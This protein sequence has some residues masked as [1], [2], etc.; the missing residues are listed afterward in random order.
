MTKVHLVMKLTLST[1]LR[2]KY[3]H[4]KINMKPV[5]LIAALLVSS[6]FLFSLDR[7]S[8]IAASQAYPAKGTWKA[9]FA[10]N[11]TAGGSPITI[12]ANMTGTFDGDTSHGL[13]IGTY[14]GKYAV[15]IVGFR[16]QETGEIKG[17][18]NVKIDDS[19]IIS[20]DITTK[21]TGLLTGEMKMTIQGTESKSG[22]LEGTLSGTVTITQY[23]HEKSER[24]VS[25]AA[26][27][28]VSGEFEGKVQKPTPTESP[29]PTPAPSMTQGSTPQPTSASNTLP[30]QTQPAGL[31]PT[32]PV[33]IVVIITAAAI[34]IYTAKRK[35]G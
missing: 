4:N 27:V 9:A 28:P 21:V 18:Y 34:G 26:N 25:G 17:E 14:V 32:I 13:W 2:N 35:K 10:D 5:L 3:G 6:A 23:I 19:G 12:S 24:S 22:D 11:G 20:G 31:D 30:T 29:T 16:G 15:F 1:R 7:N 33:L 8:A